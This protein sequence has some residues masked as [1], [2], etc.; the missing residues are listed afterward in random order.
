MSLSPA[1]G[2]YEWIVTLDQE[3]NIVWGK[4]WSYGTW[5]FVVTRYTM[6]ATAIYQ[7]AP[8]TAKVFDLLS[9]SRRS[10]TDYLVEVCT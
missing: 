5:L 9:P 1:V 7:Q 10:L 2:V 3:R 8:T 6:L 4:K